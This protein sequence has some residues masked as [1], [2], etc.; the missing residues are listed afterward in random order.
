MT[1]TT[2]TEV[3]ERPSTS[4]EK[5]QI[6]PKEKEEIKPRNRPTPPVEEVARIKCGF[7]VALGEDENINFQILGES[8]S[9][10]ELFGLLKVAEERVKD[11]YERNARHGL[12]LITRQLTELI[13]LLKLQLNR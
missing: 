8:V 10:I 6:D 9:V 5:E 3:V 13:T 12:P 4:T 11:A 2:T 1:D 7:L